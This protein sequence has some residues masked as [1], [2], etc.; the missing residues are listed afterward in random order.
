MHI[1]HNAKLLFGWDILAA[2]S[3]VR[4]RNILEPKAD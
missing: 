1:M 4:L 3:F 2:N